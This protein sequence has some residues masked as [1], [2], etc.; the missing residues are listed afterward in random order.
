MNPFDPGQGLAHLLEIDQRLD[1]VEQ[2]S[3]DS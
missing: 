1:A 3:V 2:T